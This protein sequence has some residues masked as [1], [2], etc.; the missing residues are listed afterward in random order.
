[1]EELSCKIKKI[2]ENMLVKLY[3]FLEKDKEELE[4]DK[5]YLERSLKLNNI[6]LIEKCAL[7]V[8]ESIQ[9]VKNVENSIKYLT[10]LTDRNKILDFNINK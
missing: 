8:V 4:D 10:V 2:K 7:Y 3:K 1:M 6:E 5:R 9:Q